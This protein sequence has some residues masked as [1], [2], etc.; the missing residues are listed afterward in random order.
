MMQSCKFRVARAHHGTDTRSLACNGLTKGETMEYLAGIFAVL[1]GI[2]LAV[3]MYWAL[4]GGA[5]PA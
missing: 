4:T 2:A 5:I 1:A 3:L